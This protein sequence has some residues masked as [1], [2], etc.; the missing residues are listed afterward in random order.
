[1]DSGS[2]E[3]EGFCRL[4]VFA[5]D[6]LPLQAA[7]LIGEEQLAEISPFISPWITHALEKQCVNVS[8]EDYYLDDVLRPTRW[9]LYLHNWLRNWT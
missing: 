6:P 2:W 1:M 8:A 4:S 9:I 7:Q 3:D 5:N